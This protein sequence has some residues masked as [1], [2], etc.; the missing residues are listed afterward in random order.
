[1]FEQHP[2]RRC[3]AAYP[4]RIAPDTHQDQASAQ[5]EPAPWRH[6]RPRRILVPPRIQKR[7]TEPWLPACRRQSPNGLRYGRSAV[8]A[9]G[10]GDP[11]SNSVQLVAAPVTVRGSPDRRRP[12]GKAARYIERLALLQDVIAGARQLVRQRFGGDNVVGP[13]LLALV[14]TLGFGAEAP[15]KI[16]CLNEGPGEIF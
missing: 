1:M 10:D 12:S 9:A 2:C 8:T 15:G 3:I 16:R 5:P 6:G 13:G 7:C 4:S 11:A 14:E